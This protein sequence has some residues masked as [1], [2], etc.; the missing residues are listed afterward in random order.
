MEK[1]LLEKTGKS[2]EEWIAIVGKENF[3]KHGEILKFLKSEHGFTH[4]Y[5][6]FVALKSRKA[7]AASNDET[8][9]IRMQYEGKEHLLPIYEKLKEII[10]GL[11]SDV[12]FVPKKANVSV[13]AKKQFALIQPS[14][15]TRIDLGLKLVDK[16]LTDRLLNSGSFGSM[17]S[18]RVKIEDITEVDEELMAWLKEAHENAR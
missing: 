3:E 5:A 18:N 11:G 16:P 7:D 17:C 13:R 9:L 12:T 8:D 1:G 15:K 4:G 6:N 10:Q 14:T 2:L